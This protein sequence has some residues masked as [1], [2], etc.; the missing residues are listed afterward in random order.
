MCEDELLGTSDY[1]IFEDW[2]AMNRSRDGYLHIKDGLV[3]E[4]EV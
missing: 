3:S 4:G 1:G 2:L